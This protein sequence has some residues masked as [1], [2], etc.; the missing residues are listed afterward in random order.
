MMPRLAAREMPATIAIGTARISG[1]GVA[2]TKTD[3]A[4]TASPDTIHAAPATPNVIG[5]NHSAYRSASRTAGA[6]SAWAASTRRTI[7]AYVLS[8]AVAVA[9][10]S[11]ADP[12]L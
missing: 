4:R 2:T 9:R 3:S 11:N 10:R 8:A 1:H 12:A 6:R 7:P 5:M